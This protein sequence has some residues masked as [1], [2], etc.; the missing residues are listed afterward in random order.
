MIGADGAG[1]DSFVDGKFA[2]LAPEARLAEASERVDEVLTDSAI[3]T[4]VLGALVDFDLAGVASEAGR[5]D[6]LVAAQLI[7]TGAIVLAWMRFALVDV[8]LATGPGETRLALATIGSGRVDAKAAVLARGADGA[9]VVVNG[10]VG[11]AISCG[12]VADCVTIDGRRVA[13]GVLV[14]GRVE[15]AVVELAEDAGLA[16]R[17]LAVEL[18]LAV[19]AGGARLARGLL[20]VV[21]VLAAVW[22]GPAVD[23]DA[24]VAVDLG[25]AGGPIFAHVRVLPALVGERA[26]QR[27]QQQGQSSQ[28]QQLVA[29]SAWAWAGHLACILRGSCAAFRWIRSWCSS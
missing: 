26:G 10:A 6:T 17:T 4:G 23:T 2:P 28:R 5:T 12:A 11:A 24:L 29:S 7:E 25:H 14:A 27:Q 18:A 9:F 15:A 22:T 20:A 19:V 13:G 1:E 16:G 21:D 3:V 8:N